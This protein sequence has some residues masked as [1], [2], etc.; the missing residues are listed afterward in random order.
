[1]LCARQAVEGATEFLAQR[2]QRRPIGIVHLVTWAAWNQRLDDYLTG[3]GCGN[4]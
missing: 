1:V 2:T 3:T 4:K